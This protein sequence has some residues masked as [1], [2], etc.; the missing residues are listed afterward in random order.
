MQLNQFV[1]K[2]LKS[3]PNKSIASVLGTDS[4]IAN[5]QLMSYPN[6]SPMSVKDF[7]EKIHN[8]KGGNLA[9]KYELEAKKSAGIKTDDVATVDAKEIENN[10]NGEEIIE[11]ATNNVNNIERNKNKTQNHSSNTSSNT[12]I[13]NKKEESDVRLNDM[14]TLKNYTV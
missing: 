1:I 4:Y 9:A 2:A 7:V 10:K 3:D 8:F 6:G 14:F 11:V 13:N 12:I 5:K